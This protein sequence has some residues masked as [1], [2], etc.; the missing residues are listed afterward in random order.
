MEAGKNTLQLLLQ[1]WR[2]EQLQI[3][4]NVIVPQ[5]STELS[6][7]A[8]NDRFS[9]VHPRTAFSR[10]R[11]HLLI[12]GLDISYFGEQGKTTTTNDNDDEAVAVYVILK[13]TTSVSSSSSSQVV[14]VHRAHKWF[15]LRFPY[16]PS[17]LAFREV[18]PM[19]EL[20]ST[21]LQSH[22]EL[23]PDVL[24]VD[25]NGQWHE[26]KA[27]IASFVGVKT[28]IPTIGVGKSFYSIDGSMKKENV[29]RDVRMAMREWYDTVVVMGEGMERAD[30]DDSTT[31]S[32][33]W[34]CNRHQQHTLVLDTV[35][36]PTGASVSD[37]VTSILEVPVDDII[38]ASIS[39]FANGIAI[40]MKGGAI[41]TSQSNEVLAYALVG[42]GGNTPRLFKHKQHHASM[43]PSTTA[44][45]GSKNPIYIS[46]GSH[47]SLIDAVVL[48]S[49]LCISRIPEPIREADL[50]G[51]HLVREKQQQHEAINPHDGSVNF[52]FD[53]R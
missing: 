1:S 33:Q 31:L 43:S 48:C 29:L 3:A 51:R 21:Q 11:S 53:G 15:T 8:I 14:V 28:G 23:K 45:R 12:G 32:N 37:E 40:P 49:K 6:F 46:V 7:N 52:C 47:I 2:E 9:L 5:S 44:A 20:I 41:E 16:I 17:Y 35:S 13:Y 10:N 42:H 24:L 34:A 26:R 39:Q 19:L 22:P 27:G 30:N 36:I 4:S 38:L 18:D 25:G 50:Y